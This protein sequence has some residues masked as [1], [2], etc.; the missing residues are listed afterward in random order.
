MSQ[1]TEPDSG[2]PLSLEEFVRAHLLP[3]IEAFRQHWQAQSARYPQQY[4]ATMAVDDW[5]EQFLTQ[6][7]GQADPA[8]TISTQPTSEEL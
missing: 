2:V 1:P 6:F 4:P 5:Y 8:L 7:L 3:D